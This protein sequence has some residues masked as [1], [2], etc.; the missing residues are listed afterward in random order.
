MKTS[1]ANTQ[2]H[3]AYVVTSPPRIGPTAI[4]IALRRRRS[5]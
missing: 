1:A 4:A 2:R 5:P 3:D